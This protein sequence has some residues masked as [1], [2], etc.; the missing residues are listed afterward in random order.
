MAVD[1]VVQ[2]VK[3]KLN[4]EFK[5]IWNKLKEQPE[6]GFVVVVSEHYDNKEES[7]A[8]PPSFRNIKEHNPKLEKFQSD[9]MAEYNAWILNSD[10]EGKSWV[11][12]ISA[13]K[14]KYALGPSVSSD[15][16]PYQ[17][18]NIGGEQQWW[19]K[20]KTH[21]SKDGKYYIV[22]LV[23]ENMMNNTALVG[24]KEDGKYSI[25]ESGTDTHPGKGLLGNNK[26]SND[27]KMLALKKL[28]SDLNKAIGNEKVEALAKEYGIIP[29]NIKVD[30]AKGA[31][32]KATQSW[33]II[34]RK[35]NYQNLWIKVM[36]DKEW[37][38]SLAPSVNPNIDYTITNREVLILVKDLKGDLD[39]L[40]K[41]LYH[42][43]IQIGGAQKGGI[44]TS[45]DPVCTAG[46][47]KKIYGILDD[48]MRGN[49]KESLK[50]L[51]KTNA[52]FQFGF[53]NEYVLQYI[54]YSEVADCLCDKNANMNAYV[55]KEGLEQ[56]KAKPPFS[57]STINNFIHLLPDINRRYKKYLKSSS[58]KIDS[59]LFSTQ[60]SWL[61]FVQT[62]VYPP[63]EVA[64][65][66]SGTLYDDLAGVAMGIGDIATN[67]LFKDLLYS[68]KY[69][70]DPLQLLSP[71]VKNLVVGASNTSNMYYGDDALL[72]S[73]KDL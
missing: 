69:I 20:S 61:S 37:V 5:K 22:P 23:Y 31:P 30:R 49:G 26:F 52:A 3:N 25:G 72:F 28:E 51:E 55:L 67:P 48:L 21:L 64:Y 11:T 38:D 65:Q 1:D 14:Q 10:N 53:T 45:F 6:K 62:Y 50:S 15:T 63:P 9:H 36:F 24:Y 35:Q 73:L 39:N 2:I 13:L 68:G 40:E 70:K 71:D 46:K 57:S 34:P 42:F 29:K 17:K 41:L 4:N 12:F 8:P 47:I 58:G 32:A 56:I 43:D 27:S 59:D 7:G 44:Q 16:R 66:N 54:A 33:H 19:K 60:Q 18:K